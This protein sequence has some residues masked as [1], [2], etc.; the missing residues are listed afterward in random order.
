MKDGAV[1]SNAGHFDVE[2]KVKDL[3]EI[4]LSKRE[5]REGVEEY[6]LPNGKKKY[7]Y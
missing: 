1:L 4:A 5:V 6:I 2:V 3:E 7:T